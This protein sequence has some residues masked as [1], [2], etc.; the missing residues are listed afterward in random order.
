MN[1]FLL[2]SAGF[3]PPCHPTRVPCDV[4]YLA[5]MLSQRMW[6]LIVAM[7][8]DAVPDSHLNL[9]IPGGWA[10]FGFVGSAIATATSRWLQFGVMLTIVWCIFLTWA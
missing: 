7:Q 2:R 10:G 4:L 5:L 9:G 8:P 1:R 6:M 3:S